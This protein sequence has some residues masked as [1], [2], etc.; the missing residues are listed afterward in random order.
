[1]QQC[2]FASCPACLQQEVHSDEGS[3]A[4][5]TYKA[6]LEV[7]GNPSI[8]AIFFMALRDE[9]VLR[10]NHVKIILTS[11]DNAIKRM[12]LVVLADEVSCRQEKGKPILINQP[13]EGK[14]FLQL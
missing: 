3:I 9:L 7:F 10:D 13:V 6:K 14:L 4:E 5:R 11:C 8:N 1:M 2:R 12:Q